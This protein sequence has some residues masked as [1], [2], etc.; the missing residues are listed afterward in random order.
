MHQKTDGEEERHPEASG[1]AWGRFR[2]PSSSNNPSTTSERRDE[3]NHFFAQVLA[4]EQVDQ[5]PG[6]RDEHDQWDE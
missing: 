2:E 3:T 4:Q 6:Q 5:H 1:A